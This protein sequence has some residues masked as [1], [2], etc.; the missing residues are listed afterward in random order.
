MYL[1]IQSAAAAAPA[2][3][4]A[5]LLLLLPQLLLPAAVR[6]RMPHGK[7]CCFTSLSLIPVF[8]FSTF[9]HDLFLMHPLAVLPHV[10]PRYTNATSSVITGM[11]GANAGV[12]PPRR[13]PPSIDMYDTLV[14]E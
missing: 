8:S 1:C 7:I 5:I 3:C 9:Q 4:A 6:H 11:R 10:R 13:S 12:N 2:L 14:Y